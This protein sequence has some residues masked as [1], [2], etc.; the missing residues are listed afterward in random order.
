MFNL[1]DWLIEIT[2]VWR[3]TL[4]MKSDTTEQNVRPATSFNQSTGGLPVVYS[5]FRLCCAII[6][7]LRAE[8]A[9]F[10]DWTRL[11]LAPRDIQFF[12]TEGSTP[13]NGQKRRLLNLQWGEK[14][15]NRR[16]NI[17]NW[18]SGK[19]AEFNRCFRHS[20]GY[21][22]CIVFPIFSPVNRFRWGCSSV[23]GL[24][25]VGGVTDVA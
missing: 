9:G 16:R 7:K 19:S 5:C 6:F 11:W 10:N 20:T 3:E 2:T 17:K 14:R 1:F 21:I 12:L 15:W 18:F 25:A 22:Y 4:K 24:R 13:P 8:W 23:M